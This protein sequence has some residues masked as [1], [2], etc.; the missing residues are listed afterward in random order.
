MRSEAMAHAKI[1]GELAQPIEEVAGYLFVWTYREWRRGRPLSTAHA[2]VVERVVA[3]YSR[4]SD[5]DARS[6][7][8]GMLESSILAQL[9]VDLPGP[10]PAGTRQEW[11]IL[12]APFY[13]DILRCAY[14]RFGPPP[15]VANMNTRVELHDDIPRR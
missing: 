3:E 1:L 12:A 10:V 5:V 4:R 13:Q 9:P 8:E 15:A 2:A 11:A 14:E 6:L 7:A